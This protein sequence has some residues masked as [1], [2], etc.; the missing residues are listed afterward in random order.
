MKTAPH[1]HRG[2]S[3]IDVANP[4]TEKALIRPSSITKHNMDKD[5]LGDC[6]FNI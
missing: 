4:E 3:P 6:L 2:I 1:T 5:D